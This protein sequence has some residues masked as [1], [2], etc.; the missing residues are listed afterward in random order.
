MKI[1]V[2]FTL[3]L[4]V[5]SIVLAQDKSTDWPLIIDRGPQDLQSGG[6]SVNESVKTS[7]GIDVGNIQL[8]LDAGHVTILFSNH[9]KK[10]SWC[11][12]TANVHLVYPDEG[13]R[14]TKVP[15][16]NLGVQVESGK[17]QQW[18]YP[19]A[20]DPNPQRIVLDTYHVVCNTDKPSPEWTP[21]YGH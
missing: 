15:G 12:V 1:L 10:Q 9:L 18:S 6:T 13:R 2:A 20:Y 7:D 17:T 8:V 19:Y 4:A 5:A 21:D 3:S 11:F 16:Y 14:N